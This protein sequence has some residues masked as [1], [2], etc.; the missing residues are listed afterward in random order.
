MVRIEKIL[1]TQSRTFR[2][3]CFLESMVQSFRRE[4][5]FLKEHASKKTFSTEKGEELIKFPLLSH[6]RLKTVSIYNAL[7]YLMDVEDALTPALVVG[8][9][10]LGGI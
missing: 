9:E 8:K 5:I 6:S 1:C 4:L 2:L 7:P 3:N 10:R